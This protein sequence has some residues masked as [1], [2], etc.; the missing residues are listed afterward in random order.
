MLKKSIFYLLL[1][2]GV[3]CTAAKKP[4]AAKPQKNKESTVLTVILE[5]QA[6]AGKKTKVKLLNI[7]KAGGHAKITPDQPANFEFRFVDD[8]SHTVKSIFKRVNLTKVYEYVDDQGQMAKK[9]MDGEPV[10]VPVRV[11]YHPEM[12]KLLVFQMMKE[13]FELMASFSLKETN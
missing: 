13:N 2:L 6:V 7:V 8:Q 10:V 11:N 12:K 5:L 9:V 4:M 3:A 1:L